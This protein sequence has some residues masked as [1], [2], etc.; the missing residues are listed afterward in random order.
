MLRPPDSFTAQIPGRV[1]G[2]IYV[3]MWTSQLNIQ[4]ILE[5][6]SQPD[7]SSSTFLSNKR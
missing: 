7:F 2:K 3:E 4:E 1:L 6:D 5:Q